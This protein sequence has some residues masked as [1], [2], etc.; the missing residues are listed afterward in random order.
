MEQIFNPKKL[1]E[2]LKAAKL[3]VAGVSST[4]RVD[5]TREL[6]KTESAMAQGVIESHETS[7][8]DD[9]IAR[10]L[11]ANA[12][13]S[14]MDIVMALWTRAVTGDLSAVEALSQKIDA[15]MKTN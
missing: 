15:I 11:I 2:E 13:I 12:G 3:P 8:T 4:G 6:T 9:E 1:T 7:P 14:L 5:Y 10:S